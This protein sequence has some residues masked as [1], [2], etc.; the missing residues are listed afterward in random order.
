MKLNNF[1]SYIWQEKTRAN[2]A[3]A[4]GNF[5]RNSDTLTKDLIKYGALHAMRDVVLND[6]GPVKNYLFLLSLMLEI[7]IFLFLNSM[8]IWFIP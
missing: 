2:A 8:L 5:V 1:V 3:G 6:I 7:L 4:L